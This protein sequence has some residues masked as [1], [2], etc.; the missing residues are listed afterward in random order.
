MSCVISLRDFKG[1]NSMEKSCMLLLV[2]KR[3][4][5]Q[6]FLTANLPK[7]CEE[8]SDRMKRHA[9]AAWTIHLT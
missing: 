9:I 4:V 2:R 3:I 6:R 8:A 1:Y 7:M 5:I